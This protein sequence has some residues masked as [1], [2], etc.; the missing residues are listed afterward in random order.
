MGEAIKWVNTELSRR[1]SQH[2][3]GAQLHNYRRKNLSYHI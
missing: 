2:E 3:Y 1:N